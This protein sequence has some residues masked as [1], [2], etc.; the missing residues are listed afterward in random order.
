MF[1]KMLVNRLVSI[2]KKVVIYR[3]FIKEEFFIVQ[4]LGLNPDY[5]NFNISKNTVFKVPI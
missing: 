5:G 4:I 2:Q 1:K 3:R